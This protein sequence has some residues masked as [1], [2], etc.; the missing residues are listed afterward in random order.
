V[1][2]LRAEGRPLREIR[3]YIDETWGDAGPATDTPLPPEGV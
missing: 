3:T 1:A 2:R